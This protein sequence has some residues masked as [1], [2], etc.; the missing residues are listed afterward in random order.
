MVP[1]LT[2]P[3][4]AFDATSYTSNQRR[5]RLLAYIIK[6]TNGSAILLT[7]LYL[8][9]VFGLKPLLELTASRRLE[10]LEK[11]RHKLRDC[12][13]NLVG[14]VSYIPIVAINKNDGSGKLYADAICQTSESYLKDKNASSSLLGEAG[15][16]EG[17]NEEDDQT[18]KLKQNVLVGK[19][20]HL[21]K[22]LNE[23][24]AYSISEIPHYK[25]VSY[26]VKDFQS[27]SDLVYFNTNE[28]F[29]V[30]ADGPSGPRRKNLSI[31]TRNEIR[32][33]KGMYISGKA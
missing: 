29:T 16:S 24:T 25:T 10:V 30:D 23:C 21:S 18:D 19:L 33:I 14:R 3:E 22:R 13:L 20:Q 11:F 32:S 27:K 12:Y 4:S 26:C 5:S 8:V 9:G 28:I 6:L 17:Y 7:V 31:E 2:I 1:I 15:Y